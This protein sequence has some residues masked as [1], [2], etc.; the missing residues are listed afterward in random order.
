MKA[1]FESKYTRAIVLALSAFAMTHNGYANDVVTQT[2]GEA[3][4][5][6]SDELL[7]SETHCLSRDALA[8]EVFYRFVAHCCFIPQPT[9]ERQFTNLVQAAIFVFQCGATVIRPFP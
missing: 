9:L 8:R 6:K 3:F 2:I 4:D 7:Y 5:L 1:G